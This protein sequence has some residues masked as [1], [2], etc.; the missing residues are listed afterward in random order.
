M[1]QDK[2]K[3]KPSEELVG[4]S[5]SLKAATGNKNPYGEVR[6]APLQRGYA[7]SKSNVKAFFN[8]VFND[9]QVEYDEDPNKPG[10]PGK[11]YGVLIFIEKPSS[12]SNPNH[13]TDCEIVD[14]QQRITTIFILA[15]ILKDQ[16]EAIKANFDIEINGLQNPAIQDRL[17]VLAATE[18]NSALTTLQ[19][20]LFLSDG[21]TA[22]L[23]T[24][25]HLQHLVDDAVYKPG[26]HINK[27]GILKDRD[28]KKGPTKAFADAIEQLRELVAAKIENSITEFIQANPNSIPEEHF[29]GQLQFI[30]K[31]SKTIL[32]NSYTVKLWS[33]SAQDGNA[34]F[35]SL[36][37][38]GKALAT[39]D[40]VKALI[41]SSIPGKNTENT[42][43]AIE[44][45][46]VEVDQFLR[47]FWMQYEGKKLTLEG[48]AISIGEYLAA[49]NKYAGISNPKHFLDTA[50]KESKVYKGLVQKANHK[51]ITDDDFSQTRLQQLA[52]TAVNYRVLLLK[53]HSI[54]DKT[55]QDQIDLFNNA[56]RLCSIMSFTFV[57]KFQYPQAVEDMYFEMAKN[58][59]DL[60]TLKSELD[61]LNTTVAESCKELQLKN[62]KMSTALG[63]LFH[64]EEAT[65]IHV[66]QASL[67]WKTRNESVEHIAP[68][69]STTD[70]TKVVGL[71]SKYEDMTADAGNLTILN[72]RA[73]SGIKQKPWFEPK[74]P[75]NKKKSKKAAFAHS[76]DFIHTMDL[77]TESSWTDAAITKRSK[78]IHYALMEITKSSSGYKPQFDKFS[79]WSANNP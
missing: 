69:T 10:K 26:C 9:T 40:I 46:V 75:S 39:K 23:K 33:D 34:A 19:N 47:I 68:Q 27:Q 53:A 16:L 49:E 61:K 73:N 31:F 64:L 44:K 18:F 22:R 8:D 6:M 48:L 4:V 65:R 7:W 42:W 58:S 1:P 56:I 35:L 17:R 3:L 71:A 32:E 38:K 54:I 12:A 2:L 57:G 55:K 37:S 59:I 63:I 36:N 51:E 66:P 13:E 76:T 25:S 74:D 78:W 62:I 21:K 29:L 45:N 43:A 50:L 11:F 52:E 79:V 77:S 60:P 41:L 24:W 72:R 70:W 5:Q 30:K 67:K 28:Q 15:S 14:G 20:F